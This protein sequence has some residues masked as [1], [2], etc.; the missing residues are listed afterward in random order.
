MDGGAGST[1][2]AMPGAG[3]G[4]GRPAADAR[5]RGAAGAGR[6]LWLAAASLLALVVVFWGGLT[7]LWHL[8]MTNEAYSHGPMIP[9]VAGFLLWRVWPAIRAA[10]WRPSWLAP[11]L[12]LISFFLLLL[13]ELTAFYTIIY[14]G[15][16]LGIVAVFL[17]LTGGRGLSIGWPAL[18]YLFFMI[19]LPPFFYNS[20]SQSLQLLSTD[21]G[22]LG[23]RAAGI[24]VFVE[25]NVIDLGVYKLQVV[26]A[27]SGLRYLFPLTSF[28][29]LVAVLYQGPVWQRGVIFLST[30]PITVL[31][32]SFRIAVIGV[33]VEHFGIQAAEGFLH[34]FEGWFI[35]IA[36]LV[37]LMGVVAVLN[38]LPPSGRP[39]W[40]RIDL[41]YLTPGE[42]QTQPVGA[43]GT[44]VTV[45]L[46]AG[47]CLLAVPVSLAISAR[48]EV[49]PPRQSFASFPLLKGAWLGREGRLE[50]DV[51][52]ALSAT[53]TIV[54]DYRLQTDPVPVNFYAAYYESQ[55]KEARI[56]S[57]RSCI[58]GG[59]WQISNVDRL[60]LD[61]TLGRD[62]PEINR[63]VIERGN[64]R[65][66]VY[67]WFQYRGRVTASEYVARLFLLIDQIKFG[68]T[69]GALVRLVT[70]IEGASGISGAEDRLNQFVV[71]F[72]DE[73]PRFIPSVP[74]EAGD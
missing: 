69:D 58:P 35:F 59:G 14:Y 72:Y 56:H 47:L 43:R 38:R 62:A 15:F 20:L 2:A 37:L 16:S 63:V 24:S 31:M 64:S 19:P 71:D 11:V 34:A 46:A 57:P 32:N 5:G 52:E 50:T 7:E 67:Y 18:A 8:W 9:L 60:S 4:R 68:R 42:M 27:C 3:N 21:I 39:A 54:A 36:C 30:L 17:A 40:Q 53:D 26:E 41:S 23:I 28:G 49:V 70:P 61:E 73:L 33:T 13:G 44:R 74:T 29:F 1:T 51:L 48:D 10:D 45:L 12:L 55:R 6:P 22:V 25:G 65:Q 66:L